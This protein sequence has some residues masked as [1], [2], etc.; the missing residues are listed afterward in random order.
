MKTDIDKYLIEKGIGEDVN[1]LEALYNTLNEYLSGTINYPGWVKGVY[2][3]RET[4]EEA[5]QEGNLFV[6]KKNGLIV[7][8]IILNHKQEAAY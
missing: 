5:I 7:G 2:P 6:L 1:E 3:V 4:A 8:S